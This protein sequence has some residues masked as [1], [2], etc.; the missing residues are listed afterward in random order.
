MSDTQHAFVSVHGISGHAIRHFDVREGS[1]RIAVILGDGT[2]LHFDSIED[3]ES[4]HRRILDA[5]M[6][7]S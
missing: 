6:G 5:Y 4:F 3:V 2:Q 1:D 7:A